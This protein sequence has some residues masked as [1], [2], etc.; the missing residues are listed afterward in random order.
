MKPV[1]VALIALVIFVP[2]CGC[3]TV[4]NL[5]S[6]EPRVYG[7]IAKDAELMDALVTHVPSATTGVANSASG[8]I[9]AAA[10]VVAFVLVEPPLSCIADTLTL[11]ITYSCEKTQAREHPR[12]P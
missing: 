12:E 7:G 9:V 2:I 8:E 5:T 3:G 10:L 4:Y 1:A 11:P 6:G